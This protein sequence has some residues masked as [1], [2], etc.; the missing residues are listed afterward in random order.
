MRFLPLRL[1]LSELLKAVGRDGAAGRVG[2]RSPVR[3]EVGRSAVRQGFSGSKSSWPTAARQR[4]GSRE[5]NV[6]YAVVDG[7]RLGK[8]ERKA[9]PR[10]GKR[11]RVLDM[12]HSPAGI[13]GIHL[14]RAGER[15]RLFIRRPRAAPKPAFLTRGRLAP[16]AGCWPRSAT[17][18]LAVNVLG[19]R[20]L[21]PEARRGGV[22]RE[23]GEADHGRTT[24]TIWTAIPH[25][26]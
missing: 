3:K 26:D 14:R 20:L 10:R 23:H 7:P 17:A 19:S 11:R 18:T 4:P 12:A 6:A 22:G 16:A 8:P 1:G 13:S 21:R 2:E 5:D 25:G 15:R 9:S 24:G